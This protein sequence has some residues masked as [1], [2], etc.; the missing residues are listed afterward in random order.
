[1]ETKVTNLR[2]SIDM[3]GNTWIQMRAEN[4]QDARRYAE[5]HKDKPQRLKLTRWVDDRTKSA[6]AYAWEL[7]GKLSEKLGMPSEEIY[8]QLIP[9]VGVYVTMTLPAQGLDL[10]RETWGNNGLGWQVELIGAAGPDM[11]DVKAHY[12]S[13]TYDKTQMARLIDLIIQECKEQDIEYL[14]PDRLARML[15]DWRGK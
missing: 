7:L 14:P 2:W 3:D 13:S 6:N 8:Y 5:M 12:G 10:F 4:G 11:V 9:D 1:M 15:E